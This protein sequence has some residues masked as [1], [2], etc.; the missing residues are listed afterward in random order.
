MTTEPTKSSEI[1]ILTQV[2]HPKSRRDNATEFDRSTSLDQKAKDEAS[3]P[4]V[5]QND[6]TLGITPEFIARVTGHVR[7][8][9]EAE[10][11]LSVLD[12][13]RDAIKKDL[14][15]ELK[16]EVVKAQ[17]ALQTN[18]IN[19]IDKTKAD[20][21]TELP[22]MYQ[23]SAELAQLDLSDK[24]AEM[25]IAS[26]TNVDSLLSTVLQTTVQAASEQINA[27][28]ETLQAQSCTQITEYI[29]TQTQDF[30]ASLL[31]EHQANLTAQLNGFFDSS[32]QQAKQTIEKQ[33][34]NLSAQALAQVQTDFTEAMPAIYT[35]TVAEEQTKIISTITDQL[36]QSLQI[37]QS[38]LS[39]A[40][41][42]QL[43]QQLSAA[44]ETQIEQAKMQVTT[45][46]R[47]IENAAMLH[48]QNN[49]NEA[50]PTIYNQASDE[51]KLKFT[52]DMALES[53]KVRQDFLE[54]INAD[55][56][57]VQAVLAQNINQILAL[58]LP[59][60]QEDLRKQLTSQLQDLLLNVKFVLPEQQG[61]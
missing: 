45:H 31:S 28:V 54:A 46:L 56:P 36:S 6:P 42:V 22:R 3:S 32:H 53:A 38:Q 35:Q 51:V 60:L 30:Q 5:G 14:I 13:V 4:R 1:P 11:T 12:S 48:M 41:Q 37:I 49:L 19:F 9:L 57:M 34:E 29:N 52:N 44:F 55:L 61:L 15:A 23:A 17:S 21:K 7:P 50:V 33:I 10:I 39:D 18:T 20:L 16:L 26:V 24:I 8:R 59:E 43:N 40:H 58:A 2:Y 47:D 25:Q 27:H